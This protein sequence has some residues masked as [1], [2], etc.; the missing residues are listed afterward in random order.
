MDNVN[1]LKE[2]N[3]I[4]AHCLHR[5]ATEYRKA[6]PAGTF[7][8]GAVA[9]AW[10]VDDRKK[11][12]VENRVLREALTVALLSLTDEQAGAVTEILDRAGVARG[13]TE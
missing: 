5:A 1:D 10:I 2:A 3:R 6:H 8:D 11:L 13:R 7:P 9:L 4:Y 12:A